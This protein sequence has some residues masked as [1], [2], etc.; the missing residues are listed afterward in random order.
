MFGMH[1]KPR[2]GTVVVKLCQLGKQV[3]SRFFFRVGWPLLFEPIAGRHNRY[4]SPPH[5]PGLNCY[6]YPSVELAAT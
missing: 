1:M 3:E 2:T 4:A 5:S 6:A